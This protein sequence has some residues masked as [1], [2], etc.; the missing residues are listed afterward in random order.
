P[1]IAVNA[2][3]DAGLLEQR[4][5]TIEQLLMLS[6]AGY[7]VRFAQAEELA[8]K[9]SRGRR[10]GGELLRLWLSWWRDMLLI[11]A[12][13]GE[14]VANVDYIERM[15]SW[16]ERLS[17]Q[18]IRRFIGSLLMSQ[19]CLAQNA[20]PRLVAESLLLELPRN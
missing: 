1:G 18:Q 9:W 10:D 2:A 8:R 15:T 14:G 7:E 12:G 6:S 11:K 3:T 16:A 20:S 5:K 13:A 19:R 4:G 17:L